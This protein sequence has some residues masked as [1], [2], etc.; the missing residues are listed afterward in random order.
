MTFS[1]ASLA[2]PSPRF[3]PV[4]AACEVRRG[5]VRVRLAGAA[6]ALSRAN[7]RARCAT[8]VRT[9][10]RRCPA[11]PRVASVRAIDRTCPKIQVVRAAATSR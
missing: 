10:S 11:D 6:Y 5:P 4:L 1:A 8:S 2:R 3:H 9:G 7:D